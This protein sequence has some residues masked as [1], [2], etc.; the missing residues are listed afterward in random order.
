MGTIN[1]YGYSF[2]IERTTINDYS[3]KAVDPASGYTVQFAVQNLRLPNENKDAWRGQVEDFKL[4]DYGPDYNAFISPLYADWYEFDDECAE[5]VIEN[6]MHEF[7]KW[8]NYIH[9]AEK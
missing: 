6:C 8:M 7:A 2:I 9:L 4:D 1:K 3:I 5:W